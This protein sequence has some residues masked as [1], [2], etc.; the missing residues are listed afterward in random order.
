MA[1]VT[2]TRF[3][4][5]LLTIMMTMSACGESDLV[6]VQ[7][8][9]LTPQ[10][11]VGG[12]KVVSMAIGDDAA[13]LAQKSPSLFSPSLDLK[14]WLSFSGNLQMNYDDGLLRYRGCAQ[15]VS[16][17]A[18]LSSSDG[19]GYR[20]A[21]G[22]YVYSSGLTLIEATG[23]DY[24]HSP[25]DTVA[26]AEKVVA[27]IEATSG[28]VER[29]FSEELA[30]INANG[31]EEMVPGCVGNAQGVVEPA[32]LINCLYERTP[33]AWGEFVDESKRVT[34]ARLRTPQVRADIAVHASLPLNIDLDTGRQRLPREQLK[35]TFYL[36]IS[37]VSRDMESREPP[38]DPFYGLKSGS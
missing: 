17:S 2:D 16:A 8:P 25:A 3:A 13:S 32:H 23:C 5:A 1:S 24:F 34:F 6:A 4:L 10:N 15:H 28:D 31:F 22:Q 33:E 20:G 11:F 29:A 7:G 19:V 37:F 9:G 38:S 36:S 14:E 26:A 30:S 21:D 18:V 27:Q 35:P 12:S